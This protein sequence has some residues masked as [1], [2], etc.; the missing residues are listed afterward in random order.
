MPS[1]GQNPNSSPG[2]DYWTPHQP[3]IVTP[4]GSTHGFGF[5]DYDNVIYTSNTLWSDDPAFYGLADVHGHSKFWSHSSY[6][7]SSLNQSE[8]SL[9]NGLRDHVNE[10]LS[11]LEGDNAQDAENTAKILAGNME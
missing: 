4:V 11:G 5:N 7:V 1:S 6:Y 10:I 9:G 8:E 2:H 3:H